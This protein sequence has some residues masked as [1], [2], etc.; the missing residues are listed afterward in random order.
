MLCSAAELQ[1]SEDHDGII[2]LP[3]DAPVGQPYAIYAGLDDAVIE[4][5]V[6]PNRADALGVAGVARD[7]AAAG[8]GTLKTP[9]VPARARRLPV[10][11]QGHARLRRRRPEAL[12]GL[13]A[14][15]GARRQERPLAGM[16]AGAPARDRPAPD[17]RAGRHHQLHDLRPQP[18]AARLRRGQGHGRSHR[19]PRQAGRAAS[20][21]STARPTRS[22]TSRS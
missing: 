11:G 9:S 17:Q 19:A 16:A 5:A 1:L 13:R 18:A 6:T 21:R 4:I 8:L 12:P 20:S 14:A 22:P 3:D 10:P 7:L 2:D 15:A